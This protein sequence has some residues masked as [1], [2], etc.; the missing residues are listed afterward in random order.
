M[1]KPENSDWD[2]ARRPGPGK[3]LIVPKLVQVR[4]V[5]GDVRPIATWVDTDLAGCRK[6]RKSTS[7]EAIA[8]MGNH[9]IK[10]WSN[11]QGVLALTSGEAE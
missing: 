6:T 5:S 8:A 1:S 2:K 3:D 11:T 4:G 9:L 10:G 7:G